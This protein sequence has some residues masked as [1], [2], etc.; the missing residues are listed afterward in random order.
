MARGNGT[1]FDA[2]QMGDSTR[3]RHEAILQY[4]LFR[5]DG[6]PPRRRSL[7]SPL[8]A[9]TFFVA[10]NGKEEN[11]GTKELPLATLQAAVDRCKPGD[12]CVV[13]PGVYREAVRLS[14]SGLPGQPIVIRAEGEVTLDGTDPLTDLGNRTGITSCGPNCPG[15]LW[16]RRSPAACRSR[17]PGGRTPGSRTRGYVR[18]G[19][20]P[21][22]VLRRT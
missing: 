7:A 12:E 2:L 17:R 15:R 18:N 10:Q 1:H 21:R 16:N 3:K 20:S 6:S 14:K 4:V 5:L 9:E 8:C 11:P 22:R 19:P 13:L